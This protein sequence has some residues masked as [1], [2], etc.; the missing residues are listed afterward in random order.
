MSFISICPLAPWFLLLSVHPPPP[1]LWLLFLSAYQPQNLYLYRPI[2]LMALVSS[3][4]HEFYSYLL[5]G[6]WLLFLSV[7]WLL[8][9]CVLSTPRL[10]FLSAHRPHDFHFHLPIGPMT[11]TPFA[12]RA[13]DFYSYL[14]N[15]TMTF[16]RRQQKFYSLPKRYKQIR[17]FEQRPFVGNYSLISRELL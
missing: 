13:H 8:F 2:N 17:R 5:I 7:L 16:I 10:L 15:G 3:S 14:P 4:A 11:F 1:P 9:L 12:Y 6:S